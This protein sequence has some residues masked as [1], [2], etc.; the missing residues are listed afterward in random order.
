MICNNCGTANTDNS[1]FCVHC[2][3]NLL[4]TSSVISKDTPSDTRFCKACGSALGLEQAVCL[5]CGVPSKKGSNYCYFCG[6]PLKADAV[7]CINCG[8]AACENEQS[9]FNV[10]DN[11]NEYKKLSDYEKT[12]GVIW[13]VLGIIQICTLIGIICGI[14]N[15]IMACQR[16]KY[17]NELL[18]KPKN[19]VSD[20]ENQLSGIVIIMIINIFL[21]AFIGIIGAAFD[22]YVRDYV[23]KNKEKFY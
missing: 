2:G 7:I 9:A 13:L 21:G 16:I 14:W 15:I 5:K 6:A 8:C 17:S 11:T 18:S 1:K 4:S 3:N 23:I 10:F 12:S 19:V 20:F 22:Y